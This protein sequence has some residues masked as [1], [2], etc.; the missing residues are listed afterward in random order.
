MELASGRTLQTPY[1]IDLDDGIVRDVRE[2]LARTRWPDEV[3]GAGW[4]Y[5]T[6][7]A[8]LQSLCAYWREGFDWRARERELNELSH[9][10]LVVDGL[11]IH[12]IR[13]RGRGPNPLPLVLTPGWPSSF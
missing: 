2:R 3:D 12:F 1:S 10:R 8:Y 11:P 4:D 9:Y 13:V 6:N 7:L 5:G